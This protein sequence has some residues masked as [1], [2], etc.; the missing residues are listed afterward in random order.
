[1]PSA[2]MLADQFNLRAEGT[3]TISRETARKWMR[4]KAVPQ[5]GRLE[6]LIKWLGL[7]SE[8]FLGSSYAPTPVNMATRDNTQPPH[9]G[10][11]VNSVLS[12]LIAVANRLDHQSIRVL[13]DVAD[14]LAKKQREDWH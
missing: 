3:S 11:K 14:A 10:G 8:E 5:V 13:V 12:E 4:G 9:L 7:R 1:M 2:T 6:V